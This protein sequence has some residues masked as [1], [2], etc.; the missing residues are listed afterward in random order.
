MKRQTGSMRAEGRNPPEEAGATTLMKRELEHPAEDQIR[1]RAPGFHQTHASIGQGLIDRLQAE[2]GP[3][4][5][6]ANLPSCIC[7]DIAVKAD[8]RRLPISPVPVVVPIRHDGETEAATWQPVDILHGS[9][10]SQVSWQQDLHMLRGAVESWFTSPWLDAVMGSPEGQTEQIARNWLMQGGKRLRPFATVAA[11]E[12]MRET[13]GAPLPEDVR[14]IAVAVECCHKA[15]LVHDDI[16]DND[17]ERYGRRA[18][19]VEYGVPVALNV[20]DLLI[21]ESYRLIGACTAPA[22]RK[23][24]M[25]MVAAQGQRDM[26]RG[27][28][29]ELCCSDS[30]RMLTPKQVMSKLNRNVPF[31]T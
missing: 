11:Y 1:Q 5:G 29:A 21:G 4:P 28:G 6:T 24:R 22:E 31:I 13:H 19:H 30:P 14:R 27:Q 9:H 10:S 12:A 8:S 23:V 16:E 26:C 20:G 25:L 17:S 18:L 7:P 3:Q 15:S 2:T